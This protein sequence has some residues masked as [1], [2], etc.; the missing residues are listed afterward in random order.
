MSLK[1]LSQQLGLSQTTVSRALNG[2]PEVNQQTRERVFKAAAEL[3]YRPNQF[4]KSLATGKSEHIGLIYPVEQKLINPVF[5]EFLGGITQ[6]LV[7]AGL[8]VSIM[9][10]TVENELEAYRHAVSSGRVDALIVSSPYCHDERINFLCDK[11]IPFI[12]H[13]RTCSR[14][15]EFNATDLPFS[16]IDID[17]AGG[18]ERATTLLINMGHQ[19]IALINGNETLTFAYHRKWGYEKALQKA[20]IAPIEALDIAV[21]DMSEVN[22]YE[23]ATRALTSQSPPTAFVVSSM[24]LTMGVKR[25]VREAGLELGKDIALVTHDDGLPFLEASKFNPALTTTYSPIRQAGYELTHH[26]YEMLKTN[27]KHKIQKILDVDLIVRGST[28]AAK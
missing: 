5:N 25:A 13:G 19:R 23:A 12:V 4:A 27:N 24:I 11:N 8:D 1:R 2:Y 17:T 21:D 6:K 14:N 3:N 20:D 16:Y 26:L 22:G 15:P 7:E 28:C 10:T 9:P 18:F